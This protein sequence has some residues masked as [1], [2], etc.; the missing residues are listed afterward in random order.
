MQRD[1]RPSEASVKKAPVVNPIKF[2]RSS[3][4]GIAQARTKAMI[5]VPTWQ[6]TDTLQWVMVAL[7]RW[8]DLA[9]SLIN[10]HLALTNV[11]R[12]EKMR[13]LAIN[14]VADLEQ[15][16]CRAQSWRGNKLSYLAMNKASDDDV[17][18]QH[19]AFS[20]NNGLGEVL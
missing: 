20:G 17:V 11:K 19:E 6:A 1:V 9:R 7:L 10:M 15:L 16:S 14:T 8:R 2:S 13:R 18:E 4:M 3:K 12:M 5:N